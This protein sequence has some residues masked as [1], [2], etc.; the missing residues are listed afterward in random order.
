MFLHNVSEVIQKDDTPWV[1]GTLQRSQQG[2]IQRNFY[3]GARSSQ[4]LDL[5]VDICAFTGYF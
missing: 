4:T 1:F 2:L 5:Q 3:M